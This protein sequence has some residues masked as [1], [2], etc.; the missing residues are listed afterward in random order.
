MQGAGT[1]DEVLIEILASRT[2]EQ[3][4]AIIKAYKNG[5]HYSACGK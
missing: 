5:N 1:N 3:M 2:P 4:K